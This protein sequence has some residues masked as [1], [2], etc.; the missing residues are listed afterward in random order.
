M[1]YKL[2]YYVVPTESFNAE[3]RI[4]YKG[5][6]YPVYDKNGRSLLLS[7]NGDFYFTNDLMKQAIK[8]WELN[9]IEVTQ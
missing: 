8:E 1:K 5:E 6:K 3:N 7:E 9:V 4:F 2:L